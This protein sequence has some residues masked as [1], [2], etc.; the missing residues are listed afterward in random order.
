MQNKKI[1]LYHYNTL[2][3]YFH[4]NYN[5]STAIRWRWFNF[6]NVLYKLNKTYKN[7]LPKFSKGEVLIEKTVSR[8]R[9]GAI[10][11]SEDMEGIL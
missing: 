11:A 6:Y 1:F 5:S 8:T 9:Q 4:N 10:S 7:N 2:L 3:K